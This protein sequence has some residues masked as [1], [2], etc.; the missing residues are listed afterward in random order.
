MTAQP[1]Q[2]ERFRRDGTACDNDTTNA[3]GWCRDP[4]CQGF[5]RARTVLTDEHRHGRP[6]RGTRAHIAATGHQRVEMGTD[7]AY[8]VHITRAAVE[9]FQHHHD[10]SER[11]ARTQL[12]TMLEDFLLV[13]ARKWTPAGYVV[14]ARDGFE[15]I[16]APSLTAV[17]GYAS[18]HSERTW[19]QLKA[20]IPSRLGRRHATYLPGTPPPEQGDPLPLE[21]VIAAI[22][23]QTVHLSRRV[24]TSYARLFKARDVSPDELDAAIRDALGA[25]GSG[26]ANRD[27]DLPG[28]QIVTEQLRWLVAD[29]AS[30][31]IGVA[32][33]PALALATAA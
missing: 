13:S 20:G 27:R 31:I 17:T 11:A 30:S 23:P 3:D 18:S 28:T 4:Q 2:C 29:D 6:P 32:K 12:R 10:G 8:D 7:E 16:L 19:D 14:L 1:Q 33:V 22:D 21:Q 26:V 15:V 24:R 9:S 5:T 25:L